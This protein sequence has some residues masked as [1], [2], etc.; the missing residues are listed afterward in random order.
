MVPE[1]IQ[2]QIFLLHTSPQDT[3]DFA[4]ARLDWMDGTQFMRSHY[5]AYV[6]NYK[7]LNVPPVPCGSCGG[8]NRSLD[9][10]ILFFVSYLSY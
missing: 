8:I 3:S 5:G 6:L 4:R 10:S 7:W 9:S 2:C 1:K